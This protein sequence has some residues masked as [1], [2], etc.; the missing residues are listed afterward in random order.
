MRPRV[1]GR[2]R[3]THGHGVPAGLFGHSQE[4]V[5]D[6]QPAADKK[7]LVSQLWHIQADQREKIEQDQVTAGDIVGVIG[8]KESVT[9]DTLCDQKKPIILE[10]ITFPETVISMAAEPGLVGGEEE[11]GRRPRPPR[12]AGSDL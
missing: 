5:A 6:A 7:E 12:E 4:R 2:R 11:A 9:G 1:Q 10:R 8:L 3:S